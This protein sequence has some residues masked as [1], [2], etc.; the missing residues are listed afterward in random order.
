VVASIVITFFISA[1]SSKAIEGLCTAYRNWFF[2]FCFVCIGLDTRIKDLIAWAGGKPAIVYWIAQ[3]FNA[4]WTLIVV[5]VLWS[6]W[7]FAPPIPPD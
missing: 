1:A 2:A 6:G 5:W 7:L 4:V 3:A